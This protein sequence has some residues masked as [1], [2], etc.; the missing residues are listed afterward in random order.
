[1]RRTFLGILLLVELGAGLA[2]AQATPQP[3]PVALTWEQVKDRLELGNP[4]L[5]AGKLNIS[6]LQAE[7]ITAHFRPNP[8][9]ALLS[10]QTKAHLEPFGEAA[11]F[12]RASVDFV[13]ER[14]N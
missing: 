11:E 4:T 9:L 5:L 13:L 7:E 14:R 12:L 6:E 10:D 2:S 3:A 1:M 8:N